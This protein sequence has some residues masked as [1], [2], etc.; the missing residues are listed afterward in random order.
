MKIPSDFGSRR[1]FMRKGGVAVAATLILADPLSLL[2]QEK[3]K[4][5]EEAP[6]SVTEDLMR[7]HGLLRRVLLAYDECA[8]RIEAN[9]DLPPNAI[10]GC[11]QIVQT[12]VENYHE[13]LEENYLFPRFKAAK[14]QVDLVDILTNQHLAGRELTQEILTLAD[15][16]NRQDAE[17]RRKIVASIRKFIRMYRPHAAREDT[18]LFPA[19]HYIVSTKEFEKLGDEFEG[20]ETR[21]FGEH[22][23][24]KMVDRIADIEKGL[25]I[26]E[27]AQFSPKVSARK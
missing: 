23:F 24:E 5:K 11:A 26:Y 25:G 16:K 10:G 13:K 3:T 8:R 21:M 9:G 22:G 6:V 12:F 4:E 27:L 19:F 17:S 15:P 14:Q 20:K 1:D 2:G 7:E 18:I